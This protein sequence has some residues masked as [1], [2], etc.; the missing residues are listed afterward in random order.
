[1]DTMKELKFKWLLNACYY[2]D[3]NGIEYIFSQVK[4]K[5]KK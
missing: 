3:G 4:H 1:M 2:P 5:F